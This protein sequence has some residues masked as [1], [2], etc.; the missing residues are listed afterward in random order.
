VTL[1]LLVDRLEKGDINGALAALNLER[2]AF[3]RLE[4]AV[5]RA[6]S[7]GG[8]AA[9][10]SLPTLRDMAGARVVVRFD[11]RN[12]QAE[13]W[14]RQHSS[15]LVTNILTDQRAGVRGAL[16]AGMAAGRNPTATA[17]DI[18]GRIDRAT[19]RRVGG[20]V[21]LSEPQVGYVASAR[22][23]LLSGDPAL[24]RKYLTRARRDARF[25]GIVRKA[26][27]A[28][29]PLDAATVSRLVG[30]YGDRLLQ[31]RGD[32]IGRTES[33][34]SLSASKHEAFRQ[35]LLKTNYSESQVVRTWDDAG[36]RK[37]RHTHHAMNGQKVRGLEAPFVSPSGARLRFPGDTNLGAGA[38]EV[39]GCR[40]I[41]HIEIDYFGTGV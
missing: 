37:V 36:D 31:L 27:D 25:D 3:A 17:L 26:I 16:E 22:A 34:T 21:G 14:L 19:G 9:I 10:G 1:R 2:G 13:A 23:E 29:K 12:L 32:M 30:R 28:G 33:L 7:T 8:S 4:D 6:Y 15:E 40:C 24:M 5:A 35:G 39:I 20:I 11:A 38:E 41:E 18:V